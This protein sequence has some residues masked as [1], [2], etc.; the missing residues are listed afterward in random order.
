M[1]AKVRMEQRHAEEQVD[2][3]SVIEQEAVELSI[4]RWC[5]ECSSNPQ[6]HNNAA[7]RY[8][9]AC[10]ALIACLDRQIEETVAFEQVPD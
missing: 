7:M 9:N 5:T 8:S 10:D 1:S 6:R 4:A 3:L 2:A